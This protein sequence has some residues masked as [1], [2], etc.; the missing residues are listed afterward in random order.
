MKHGSLPFF[1][2]LDT[3][4]QGPIHI[5]IDNIDSIKNNDTNTNWS[6]ITINRSNTVVTY[7][8]FLSPEELVNDILETYKNYFNY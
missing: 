4:D 3:Q 8:S 5:N 7:T 6:T 1:Y 2:R